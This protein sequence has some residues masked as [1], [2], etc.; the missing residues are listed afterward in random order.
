MMSLPKTSDNV[1][2]N[3]RPMPGLQTWRIADEVLKCPLNFADVLIQ[4]DC[5]PVWWPL[6]LLFQFQVIQ[7]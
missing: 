1:A 6:S 5:L 2:I 7:Q 4:E 3:Y